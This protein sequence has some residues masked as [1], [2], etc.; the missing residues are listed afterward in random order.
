LIK[1]LA[2]YLGSYKKYVWMAPLLVLLDVVAELSMP[3]LMAQI[4]DKGIPAG[5]LSFIT[6]TGLYMI[7][8]AFGAIFFGVL[9]MKFSEINKRAL[10]KIFIDGSVRRALGAHELVVG[11]QARQEKLTDAR[12][13]DPPVMKRKVIR[14]GSWKDVE[15]FIRTSTR[16]YE[17]QDTAKSYIGFRCVRTSFRNELHNR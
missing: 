16:T 4:V 8:L 11:A 9:N 3:L 14:G 10:L 7:L 12:P 13:D 1:K 17:Y 5:D 6:R 15:Y 2:Q